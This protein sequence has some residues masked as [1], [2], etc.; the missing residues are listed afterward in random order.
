M[1]VRRATLL[2]ALVM[3]AGMLAAAQPAAASHF[4]FRMT[5]WERVEGNEVKMT[6][7]FAD[8]GSYWGSV[9]VDDVIPTNISFG[10]GQ[11]GSIDARVIAVNEIEDWFLAR[12]SI[13]HAYQ[14]EGPFTAR[15]SGCCTLGS[16]KNSPNSSLRNH[17]IVDLRNGNDF[18]P[19][20]SL[21]PIV[22]VPSGGGVRQWQVHAL[23]RDNTDLSWRLATPTESSISQPADLTIDGNTG[24]VSWDTTGKPEG[25]WITTVIIADDQGAELMVTYLINL[26][27][28]VTDPPAWLD[29]TPEDGTVFSVPVG[30]ERSFTLIAE[31]PDAEE[32]VLIT[33]LGLPEGVTCTDVDNPANPA[34]VDCMVAPTAEDS[35]F[36][37]F[38]AQ[39]PN[40]TSAGFRT[41]RLE[42]LPGCFEEGLRALDGTPAEGGASKLA[43][44][45]VEPVLDGAG[46][47]YG[48]MFHDLLCQ[49][50]VPLEDEI[51]GG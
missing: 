22:G 15:W 27:G 35:D 48:D 34:R 5:T 50:V 3:V 42:Y 6:V 11:F 23:D 25:L 39:D 38:N 8:R 36:V 19:V 46:T 7:T 40:G 41:Y 2:V 4:R 51:N 43:H 10:D 20:T 9:E 26:G 18:S 49:V 13:N 32:D 28:E 17:T 14:T 21:P 1:G 31:D 16:L 24:V 30:R 12:G 29:P 44:D 45:N 47:E 37:T 33:D